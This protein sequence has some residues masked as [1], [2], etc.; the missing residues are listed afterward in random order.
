MQN[1][2]KKEVIELLWKEIIPREGELKTEKFLTWLRESDFYKAP[3]STEF[4]LN[5]EGG[6]AQ[7][8]YNVYVLLKEKCIRYN[9][10]VLKT[11]LIMCGLG[12]DLCK[13]NFYKKGIKNV[14]EDGRWIQKECYLVEDQFPMGHG[15]KSVSI[16]QNFFM[17]TEEEKLAVRWHMGMFDPSIHFSYPNGYA[18]KTAQ[19]KYALITLLQTAD[20][21]ASQILEE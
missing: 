4:H 10:D 8:S 14:K 13:V 2:A 7:H 9:I 16:L 3:C 17:L 11:T 20:I 5:R 1:I 15:E 6:L 12:H 19:K 18:F 21:E